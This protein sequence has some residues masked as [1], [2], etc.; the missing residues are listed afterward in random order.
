MGRR[1]QE[2]QRSEMSTRE[3]LHLKRSQKPQ[4]SQD[5]PHG[6][7]RCADTDRHGWRRLRQCR[8]RCCVPR[9]C[10]A[11]QVLLSRECMSIYMSAVFVVPTA[12]I[13]TMQQAH[14]IC[15]SHGHS[16]SRLTSR[17]TLC[18]PS[19][20]FS[21]SLDTSPAA[22]AALQT[23]RAEAL[24]DSQTTTMHTQLHSPQSAQA[25]TPI[26]ENTRA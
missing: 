10:R 17:L 7:N 12:V 9:L 3:T 14:E 26:C 25:A 8:I 20:V 13:P 16:S 22:A 4:R 24:T 21:L 19:L 1:C 2:R 23:V 11:F 15:Q 18:V 5:L 6:M